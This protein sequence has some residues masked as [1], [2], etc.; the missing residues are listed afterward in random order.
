M[1]AQSLEAHW[2]ASERPPFILSFRVQCEPSGPS[3]ASK[4]TDSVRGLNAWRA[5]SVHCTEATVEVRSSP[6]WPL[7]L[8]QAPAEARGQDPRVSTASSPGRS[9]VIS[10]IS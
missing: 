8:L 7:E 1:R 3:Q 5:R 10:H 2:P 4:T 9:R 6:L